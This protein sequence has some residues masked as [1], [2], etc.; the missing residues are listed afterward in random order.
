MSGSIAIGWFGPTNDYWDWILGH[1]REV[2]L[3][4]DRNVEDWVLSQSNALRSNTFE[5]RPTLLVAVESRFEPAVDFVK[6]REQT[7]APKERETRTVPWSVLLGDDWVGHRRTHPLPETL[8]TFYW[9]ELYDRLLPW[10]DIATPAAPSESSPDSS[11]ATG[12]RRTSLRVQRLI[13]TSLSLDENRKTD[14][15]DAHP[16]GLALIVTETATS[17]QL[18]CEAFSRYDIQCIATTPAHFEFWIKPD[19]IVID[20]ESEPL[21]V[22]QRQRDFNCGTKGSLVRKMAAQYPN[23]II[24]VADAFPRWENW[25]IL[26]HSGADILVGKPFQLAGIFRCALDLR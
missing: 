16:I 3:L 6:E 7:V 13:D 23:A 4:T 5:S 15:S 18:W 8:Q 9:Y 1:F 10:L 11:N 12:K 20:I 17:R 24:V 25:K 2:S 26:K 14:P 22:R 21:V 19:V